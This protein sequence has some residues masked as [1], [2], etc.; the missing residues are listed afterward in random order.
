MLVVVGD[1]VDDEAF[2]LFLVPDDGPVEEFTADRA[3][4]SFSECVGY[5]RLNG[6]AEDL[7]S[8]GS[9]D[10]VER[11]DELA[12][13]VADECTCVGEAFGVVDEQVPGGLGG[14]WSGGVGG[15]SGV[16]HLASVDLD[17][18]QDVVAAQECVIDGEEVAGDRGLGV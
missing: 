8:F 12:G 13:S 10:L 14:P 11:I 6:C 9:K 1:V 4:P 17:E 16:D 15:D 7:D 5:W 3:N 2:E 18:E